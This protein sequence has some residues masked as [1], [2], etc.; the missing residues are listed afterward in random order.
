MRI[1][2]NPAA[3][4]AIGIGIILSLAAVVAGIGLISTVGDVAAI[5]SSLTEAPRTANTALGAPPESTTTL[6]EPRDQ[7]RLWSINSQSALGTLDDLA[8]Q[9]VSIRIDAIGANAPINP[10]GIDDRTG[11]MDVPDTV[12]EVAWYRYGPSPGEPGSAVL[13]AHVDL[14]SQGPGVFFG[15]RQLDPGDEVVVAF[16]D[17]TERTFVVEARTVYQKENLPTA[18]IFSRQGPPILTL[19][20]CGGG[21]SATDERYDSNVVVYAV[22]VGT[23]PGSITP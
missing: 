14:K 19:I 17:G 9:P 23:S 3:W 5:E 8:P 11:Q 21:F 1:R 7:S 22:P 20:T 6:T 16:D 15:L 13:A 4:A 18:S 10:Y 12:G 2:K